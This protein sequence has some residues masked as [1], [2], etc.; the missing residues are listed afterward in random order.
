MPKVRGITQN[1]AAE[2]ENGRPQ[3]IPSSRARRFDISIASFV[4][5]LTIPSSKLRSRFDG[6]YSQVNPKVRANNFLQ[7]SNKYRFSIKE[8]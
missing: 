2:E 4:E 8:F 6:I 1:D 5:T 3:R 7:A